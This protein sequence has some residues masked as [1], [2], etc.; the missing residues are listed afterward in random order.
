MP[1]QEPSKPDDSC[2]PKVHHG[3]PCHDTAFLRCVRKIADLDYFTK[4]ESLKKLAVNKFVNL[5]SMNPVAF[6]LGRAIQSECSFLDFDSELKEN[7]EVVFS[8]KSAATLNKRANLIFLFVKAVV[9]RGR[10]PFPVQESE[11]AHYFF[12]LRRT[13]N[14]TSRATSL[15]EA[16]R[17][18]HYTLGLEG[19]LVACES[20]RVKGAADSMLADKRP[21]NPADPF[22]VVELK[23][24]HELMSNATATLFDRLA[25]G[26]VL[27][28]T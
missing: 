10:A 22:T 3:P 16:L 5:I 8:M 23:I 27:A 4:Q 20:G 13:G 24:F 2:K 21:W 1:V 19:A 18:C 15:R 7:L 12:Q 25:A 11:V 28:M 17:L 9:D 14:F 26:T 6:E